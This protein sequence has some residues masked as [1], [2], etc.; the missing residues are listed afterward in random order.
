MSDPVEI[1]DQNF[2][3]EVL[4]SETPVLVDFWADWCQP[5]KMIAP[6]V[7]QI[8]EEYD[9]KVKI[10]KLD[11]DSNQQTSQA[12]GIRGIPALII[13]NDGKPVDQIIGVV[14]KSIIQK[15]IDEV[16]SS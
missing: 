8:A 4:N 12:M 14:P 15:K 5:C 6:V 7:Q 13:F 9:G 1:T 10:G 3:Q 16:L 2:Q 11:V